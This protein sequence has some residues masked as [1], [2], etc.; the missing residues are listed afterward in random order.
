MQV[1]VQVQAQVSAQIAIRR[2][3]YREGQ[4]QRSIMCFSMGKTK[5]QDRAVVAGTLAFGMIPRAGIAQ[6]NSHSLREAVRSGPQKSMQGMIWSVGRGE[7]L[8]PLV[9]GEASKGGKGPKE[10]ERRGRYSN[11]RY[12]IRDIRQRREG[13][14]R[15]SGARICCISDIR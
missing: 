4:I 14:E 11:L 7:T 8:R 1:Q 2:P 15:G 13:R 12:A 9:D 5:P 6:L 10:A 3:M